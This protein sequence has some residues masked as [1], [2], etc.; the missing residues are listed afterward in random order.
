MK[1]KEKT[2]YH[3]TSLFAFNS[4]IENKCFWAFQ[5]NDMNDTKE[6]KLVYDQV[7]KWFA[8]NRKKLKRSNFGK[9]FSEIFDF[10]NK[11]ENE[12]LPY[13]LS[14][15]S[16]SDD[17]NQWRSY[18]DNGT[19][20]CIGIEIVKQIKEIEKEKIL[21]NLLTKI[22]KLKDIVRIVNNE[23]NIGAYYHNKFAVQGNW[24]GT[25]VNY[26]NENNLFIYD[27]LNSCYKLLSKKLG[28]EWAGTEYLDNCN[29]AIS[30]CLEVI[31]PSVKDSSFED[32]QEYRI[33]CFPDELKEEYKINH[34]Q[35]LK[36]RKQN[37]H[38]L[39]H[40]KR[41]KMYQKINLGDFIEI[42]NV[43]LG[44]K[45]NGSVYT[46]RMLLNTFGFEDVS[47]TK[48]IVPYR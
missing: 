9:H 42:K 16:K 48:S 35:S 34:D 31:S 13:V 33:L 24:L 30:E 6:T 12:N 40:D 41:L 4:I 37:I 7:E 1:K 39:A 19:G 10:T 22:K 15:S 44:P 47:I 46:I 3:Y 11:D 45:Y 29:Y 14:L 21:K 5:L 23:Y 28:E 18:A 36:K 26:T 25:K 38:F 27:F 8:A 20:I 43:I 2:Y 17:L 32:E